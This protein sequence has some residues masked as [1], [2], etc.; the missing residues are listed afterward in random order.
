MALLIGAAYLLVR[1]VITPEIPIAFIGTVAFMTW[2]LG[3]ET[4]FSG[5][6]ILPYIYQ[7]G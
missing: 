2:M 1:R 4:A 6:F 5:D 3:G 7:A